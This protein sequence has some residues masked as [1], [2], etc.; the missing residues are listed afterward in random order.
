M[1]TRNSRL[2]GLCPFPRSRALAE[3]L[4]LCRGPFAADTYLFAGA[5]SLLSEYAAEPPLKQN[6]SCK[7]TVSLDNLI[8]AVP[9][10]KPVFDNVSME[11]ILDRLLLQ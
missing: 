3:F 4:Q 6:V 2:R 9:R 8:Q 5:D 10:K 11:P 7:L 1:Q